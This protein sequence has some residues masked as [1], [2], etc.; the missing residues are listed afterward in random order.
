MLAIA[1]A[2]QSS[3]NDADP[4]QTRST[5][6]SGFTMK[7]GFKFAISAAALTLAIGCGTDP[8]PSKNNGN[9]G[10]SNNPMNNGSNSSNGGSNVDPNAQTNNQNVQTNNDTTTTTGTNNA[11]PGPCEVNDVFFGQIDSENDDHAGG[12]PSTDPVATDAGLQGVMD[13]FDIAEEE[14]KEISV[15]ITGAIVT[16]TN[17]GTGGNSNF[18]VE[19]SNLAMQVFLGFEN[20]VDATVN[21]G[22]EVNF[23]ATEINNFGG[24]PQLSALEGFEIVSDGNPVPYTDL[25]GQTVTA[26]YYA[27]LVRIGGRL[28]ATGMDCGGMSTCYTLTH[29]DETIEY[30]TSSEFIE[31][32]ECVTFFG[33]LGSFPGPEN[34][35]GSTPS[36]QLGV[37]NFSWSFTQFE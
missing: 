32:G 3:Q 30:R 22:D 29:G 5:S 31:G 26:D 11:T 4:L 20:P 13:E 28:S 12:A 14:S 35:D 27:R 1:P 15:E 21:V 25:T 36:W 7:F 6:N 23:T 17:F 8:D 24:T 10:D 9:N 2:K 37:T 33:P 16:A 34:D 19:D 18:W